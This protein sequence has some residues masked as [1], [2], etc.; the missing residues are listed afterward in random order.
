MINS[1]TRQGE[2][3]KKV[4]KGGQELFNQ[5]HMCNTGNYINNCLLVVYQ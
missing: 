5:D 4:S 3:K 1:G 2:K